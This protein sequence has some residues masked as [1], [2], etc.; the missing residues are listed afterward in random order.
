MATVARQPGDVLAPLKVHNSAWKE[1]MT[2][3]LKKSN[4]QPDD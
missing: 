3:A 2:N 4:A 1:Q